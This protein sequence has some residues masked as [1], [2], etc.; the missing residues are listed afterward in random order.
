MSAE[1]ALNHGASRWTT[2]LMVHRL[3]DMSRHGCMPWRGVVHTEVALPAV[4]IYM[5]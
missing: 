2:G 1:N 5:T 3:D 4:A